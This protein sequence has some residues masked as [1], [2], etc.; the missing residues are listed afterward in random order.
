MKQR[1]GK[2]LALEVQA[3]CLGIP[4]SRL[5]KL[6]SDDMSAATYF[7]RDK[8][9]VGMQPFPLKTGRVANSERQSLRQIRK[10]CGLNHYCVPRITSVAA[11]E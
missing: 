11:T 5:E 3:K 6:P 4:V 7:P 10:Q 9:A 8:K 1:T 2:Q